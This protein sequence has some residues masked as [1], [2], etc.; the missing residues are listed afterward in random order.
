[1]R[2]CV[3]QSPA[4]A[5]ETKRL[6]EHL[7]AVCQRASAE[8][9]LELEPGSTLD[10]FAGKIRDASVVVVVVTARLRKGA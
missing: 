6:T 7:V 2:V 3:V 10:Q 1:M 9:L 5:S 4:D 8:L